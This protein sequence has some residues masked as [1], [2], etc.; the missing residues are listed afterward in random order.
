[1]N[2]LHKQRLFWVIVIF[3]MTILAVLL[4]LQALGE[5]INLYFSPTQIVNQTV[6]E[7]ARIRVGGIVKQGSVKRGEDLSVHFVI[8]DYNQE[9]L[10]HYQGI[11]PDL[12]REGQ[13]IVTL[14][15]LKDTKPTIILMADE[16]LAKHDEKYMPPE[17]TSSLQGNAK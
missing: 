16:V 11:L 3:C 15:R 5:N 9:L 12:F 10:V 17:L 8:T 14:G 13:G 4:I 6:P 2:T 7:K 1:L